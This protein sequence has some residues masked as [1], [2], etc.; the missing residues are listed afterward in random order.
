ML[1]ISVHSN[2]GYKIMLDIFNKMLSKIAS[3]LIQAL[4]LTQL[5]KLFSYY[6]T[7]KN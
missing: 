7:H 2:A 4:T 5:T 3:I 6:V 1:N